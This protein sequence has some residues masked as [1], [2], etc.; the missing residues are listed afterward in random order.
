[1]SIDIYIYIKAFMFVV[2]CTDVCITCM[3][4]CLLCPAHSFDIQKVSANFA[5]WQRWM[6]GDIDVTSNSNW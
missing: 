2:F 3:P 5:Q 1:M 6:R 4:P